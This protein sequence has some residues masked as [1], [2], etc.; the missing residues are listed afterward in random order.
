MIG[1]NPISD[2]KAAKDFGIE[3]RLKDKDMREIVKDLI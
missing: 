3:A 1:D 2:V